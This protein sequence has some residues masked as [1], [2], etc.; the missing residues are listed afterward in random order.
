MKDIESLLKTI[1]EGQKMYLRHDLT[2]A[3]LA[4]ELH[5][6]RTYLWAYFR[7]N[8][9][10]ISEYLTALRMKQATKLLLTTNMKIE[11]VCMESGYNHLQTF[12]R[13]FSETFHMSPSEYRKANKK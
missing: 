2:A 12:R 11:A 1:C 3:K 4:K 9:T 13:H 5:T 7:E 10:D 8:D 6:N